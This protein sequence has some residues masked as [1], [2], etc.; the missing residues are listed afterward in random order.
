MKI[1][2]KIYY[3]IIFHFGYALI[4]N[5]DTEPDL[6]ILLVYLN[7]VGIRSFSMDSHWCT[8]TFKDNTVFKF[9]NSNKWYA[10]MSQGTIHFSNGKKIS[11]S[12]GMPSNEVLVKYSKVI[13]FLEK[14]QKSLSN[15][16]QLKC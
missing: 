9:W 2:R 3:Y 1:L 5:D 6:D 14:R 10:W 8:L 13:T 12:S 11:W 7:D 15:I 4:R 16:Y